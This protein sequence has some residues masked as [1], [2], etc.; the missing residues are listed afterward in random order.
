MTEYV[1]ISVYNK[2]EIIYSK[3]D[4]DDFDEVNKIKWHLQKGYV[5]SKHGRLHRFIMKAKKGDPIIDH[6]NNDKLDNRKSNLRF[7]NMSQNSQ[8]KQKKDG[9][10]SEY[11]G[12]FFEDKNKWRCAIRINGIKKQV[13]F[14]NE[15]HAAYYY[16]CLA[17]EHYGHN[18]KINGI[19]IP[20][21]F[22]EPIEKNKDLPKGVT[23]LPSGNYRVLLGKTHVGVFK[24]IEDAENAYKKANDEKQHKKKLKK[25]GTT[26]ERNKEGIAIIKTS[27]RDEILVDDDKY[28]ELKQYTWNINNGYFYAEIN[29]KGT[30]IHRYLMK[31]KTTEII[32]HVNHNR[33]DNRIINLRI[34]N[35]SLNNHNRSKMLNTTSKFIGVSFENYSQKYRAEIKHKGKKYRLGRFKNEIEAAKAYNTKAHELYG[36]E[37]NLNNID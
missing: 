32:D 18:T 31:P 13:S 26:I 4:K 11:I 35:E 27:K 12:V 1:E 28:F 20:E 9:C 34:C 17:L 8:N 22:V 24:T 10:T 6:I 7:A 21:D 33:A 37:A 29:G 14:E 5:A 30:L 23:N 19:E 36:D 3:I 25:I 16:D 15:E 2:G